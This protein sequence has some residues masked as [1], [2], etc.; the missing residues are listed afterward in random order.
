MVKNAGSL[1]EDNIVVVNVSGRGD[2]DIFTVAEAFAD[3]GWR[4]FIRE[5]AAEYSDA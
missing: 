5:K 2:K 1:P 3:P 4:Q